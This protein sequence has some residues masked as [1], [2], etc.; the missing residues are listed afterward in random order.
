MD[1]IE[2]IEARRLLVRAELRDFFLA[3]RA[4]YRVLDVFEALLVLRLILR[5]IGANPANVLVFFTYKASEP[6]ISPFR[7]FLGIMPVGGFTLEWPAA[8]AIVLWP[9][10]AFIIVRILVLL[11]NP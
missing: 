2:K 1:E 10:F 4:I 9:V 3:R 7:G 5:A 6:L 11:W 8:I